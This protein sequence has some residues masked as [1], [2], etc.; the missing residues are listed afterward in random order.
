MSKEQL[1]RIDTEQREAEV[2]G[3]V[4]DLMQAISDNNERSTAEWTHSY[5]LGYLQSTV[6]MFAMD[7]AKL[8]KRIKEWTK[9]IND[10]STD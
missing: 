3:I 1:K 2:E 4:K 5:Q 7:N 6:A 9:I 10:P 8:R